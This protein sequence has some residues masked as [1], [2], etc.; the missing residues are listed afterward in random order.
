M[1]LI[2]FSLSIVQKI[3][4]NTSPV[5]R[6]QVPIAAGGTARNT[7]FRQVFDWTVDARIN[8]TVDAVDGT[9]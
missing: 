4:K 2:I 3:L 7:I 9:S 6:R 8:W 1:I 5:K